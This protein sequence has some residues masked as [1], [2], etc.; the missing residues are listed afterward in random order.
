M[1]FLQKVRR[2]LALSYSG[3]KLHTNG[4]QNPE[5]FIFWAMFGAF[6]ALWHDLP[7]LKNQA[8][9]LFLLYDYLISGK[10]SGKKLMTLFWGIALRS[11]KRTGGQTDGRTDEKSQIHRALPLARVSNKLTFNQWNSYFSILYL[12]IYIYLYYI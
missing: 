5:N 8:S 3:E 9:S 1:Q 12:L 11:G 7:F 2:P 4:C 10:K 6:W